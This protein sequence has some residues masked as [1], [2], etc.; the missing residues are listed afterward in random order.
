MS[1]RRAP[2]PGEGRAIAR[3]Q[4]EE[5]EGEALGP[6]QQKEKTSTRRE[7]QQDIDNQA[8][9]RA[10]TARPGQVARDMGIAVATVWSWIRSGA[11]PASQ[12]HARGKKGRL[13]FV[14]EQSLDEFLKRH[15]TVVANNDEAVDPA[16]EAARILGRVAAR[17][18]HGHRARAG[19]P[20][21]AHR[22]QVPQAQPHQG[23]STQEVPIHP[24]MK[25]ILV[26]WLQAGWSR[27]DGPSAS[28]RRPPDTAATAAWPG[29]RGDGLEDVQAIA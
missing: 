20:R 27:D 19:T 4:G 25:E 8:T 29:S 23:R 6:E 10:R 3:E 14:H 9:P 1:R 13:Y 11:L 24:A 15:M 17:A 28:A 7:G 21:Q 2:G 18:A 22:R 12:P 16:D 26:E 5:L